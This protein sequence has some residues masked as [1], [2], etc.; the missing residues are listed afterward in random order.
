MKFINSLVYALLS[1]TT[2]AILASCQD[3][4]FGYTTE[5]V[6]A[7]VY[8]R[9]FIKYYGEIDP[10]QSWDF[11]SYALVNRIKAVQDSMALT[12]GTN[13]FPSEDWCSNDGD[14]KGVTLTYSKANS[15]VE[16]HD[17]I[18]WLKKRLQEGDQRY[19]YGNGKTNKEEF[20]QRFSMIAT[21]KSF[22]LMP[23]YQGIDNTVW[24]FHVVIDWFDANGDLQTVDRVLWRKSQGMEMKG[25]RPDLKGEAWQDYVQDFYPLGDLGSKNATDLAKIKE[26]ANAGKYYNPEDG[27]SYKD[28]PYRDVDPA[29]D[30]RYES[31]RFA[32]DIKSQWVTVTGYPQGRQSVINFYLHVLQDNDRVNDGMPE[33][34]K[35]KFYSDGRE[36]PGAIASNMVVLPVQVDIVEYQ[37]REIVL[38]GCETAYSGKLPD[39][40][41]HDSLNNYSDGT[42]HDYG[43]DDMNDIVFLLIGD[44][45]SKKLP[46]FVNFNEVRK[47]YFFEDLGSVVDWDFND[48]VLDME[49]KLYVDADGT[50]MVKQTATL[51]HRCGTTP[52]DLWLKKGDSYEKIGFNQDNLMEGDH[53]KGVNE[54]EEMEYYQT[55]T[56]YDG[57]CKLHTVNGINE[58]NLDDPAYAWLPNQN[59]V[60]I[61][62]YPKEPYQQKVEDAAMNDGIWSGYKERSEG[63]TIPRVFVAD[64]SVWWTPENENFPNM[65]THPETAIVTKPVG[66]IGNDYDNGSIYGAGSDRSLR[67]P[68]VEGNQMILWN[69]PTRYDKWEPIWLSEGFMEGI[70]AGYNKLNIE[71]GESNTQYAILYREDYTSSDKK[72]NYDGGEW[73]SIPANNIASFVI[74]ASGN[75]SVEWFKSAVS[76]R[77]SPS[78]GIQDLDQG[79][80]PHITIN[81]VWL[82]MPANYT[83]T[84]HTSGNGSVSVSPTGPTYR[85]GSYVT[86]T[87]TPE[88]GCH[89][90]QWEDGSKTSVRTIYMDGNKEI[91]ATFAKGELVEAMV[92]HW[93]GNQSFEDKNWS[94]LQNLSNPANL[95]GAW[96]NGYDINTFD[97]FEGTIRIVLK[98]TDISNG[99]GN[100]FHLSNSNDV[101]GGW[102]HAIYE[103]ATFDANGI[104]EIELDASKIKH[105]FEGTIMVQS[106]MYF[107]LTDFEVYKIEI[108]RES[109]TFSVA[110][111]NV[112]QGSV[113]IQGASGTSATKPEGSRVTIV[114]TPKPNYAFAA[115][116][117]D[118][119]VVSGAGA[120]YTFT[121]DEASAG[122]YTASFREAAMYTITVS[123]GDNGSV[124]TTTGGEYY[125][126]TQVTFTATPADGYRVAR[127]TKNGTTIAGE[128]KN[129]LTI[130]V[131]GNDRY[132]VEFEEKPAGPEEIELSYSDPKLYLATI[133]NAGANDDDI[134]RF[135]ITNSSGEGRNGWGIG[136]ILDMNWSKQGVSWTG[137][138]GTSWTY[139]YTV[140]QVKGFANGTTG[141]QYN[142]Y[143]ACKVTKITLV[144]Q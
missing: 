109:H 79:T 15:F 100:T 105:L 123:A 124:D 26:G 75:G 29:G 1:M 76:N 128:T 21:E 40:K 131:G 118:G 13:N 104:F 138:E 42:R 11:S 94:E 3:E 7:G 70:N 33:A 62:V 86:V 127:W 31:T 58:E 36:T 28:S 77:F 57:L 90:E 125:E 80:N 61:K 103:G 85:E 51:K 117:K 64:P 144:K 108:A 50:Q 136:E 45:V 95:A 24:D 52:F 89:F 19:Q 67:Y 71:F 143:N 88:S 12:R 83:L 72:Y 41:N 56:L 20:N 101:N 92:A 18:A 73:H 10:N 110:S 142:I 119:S 46:E 54:G 114:A 66:A 140:S 14:S 59:N 47:R 38:L 112:D 17:L 4:D 93:T 116:S 60:A 35:N 107:T 25:E 23:V 34:N 126:G 9:N 39:G 53:I 37:D 130:T 139:E 137:K 82:T 135:Y 6:R 132:G 48:V 96:V 122:T 121:L 115:W 44:E 87:A 65:W 141:I 106:G 63:T 120:S 133:T 102:C 27:G 99:N 111:A 8:D 43:D 2:L 97:G 5:E 84:T 22:S 68:F 16:S 32:A 81:K 113:S 49:H 98:A 78:I 129:S 69:T 30:V 134:I 74:P 91:T 55:V